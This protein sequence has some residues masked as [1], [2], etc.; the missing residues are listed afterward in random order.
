[1]GSEA[2]MHWLLF[3][4]RELRGS[5]GGIGVGGCRTLRGVGWGG[6]AGFGNVTE[7]IRLGVYE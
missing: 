1:M 6:I 7:G 4:I 3:A 5:R 2:N